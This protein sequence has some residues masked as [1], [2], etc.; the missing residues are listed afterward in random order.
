[1]E[2]KKELNLV[3]DIRGSI[4]TE[5]LIKSNEIYGKGYLP[6]YARRRMDRCE[7][8]DEELVNEFAIRVE[9]TSMRSYKNRIK[10]SRHHLARLV[11]FVK[12]LGEDTVDERTVKYMGKELIIYYFC[13]IIHSVVLTA[14]LFVNEASYYLSEVCAV[15]SYKLIF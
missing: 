1:M 8:D 2:E 3:A 15:D 9:Y 5:E 11:E 14:L 12:S 7:G 13:N 10:C 4:I 6:Y